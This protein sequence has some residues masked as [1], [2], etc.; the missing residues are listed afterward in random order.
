MKI[1]FYLL[2]LLYLFVV[3]GSIYGLFVSELTVKPGWTPSLQFTLSGWS[4]NLLCVFCLFLAGCIGAY[5]ILLAV[6]RGAER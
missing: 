3:F 4:K 6:Y 5:P 1:G 2:S